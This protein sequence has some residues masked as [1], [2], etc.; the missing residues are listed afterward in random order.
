MGDLCGSGGPLVLQDDDEVII[1]GGGPNAGADGLSNDDTK[2]IG[3]GEP[4]IDDDNNDQVPG[5]STGGQHGP[6]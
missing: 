6:R 3:H 2:C 1:G 5:N 4:D